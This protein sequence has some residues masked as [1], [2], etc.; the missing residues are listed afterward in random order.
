MD[1]ATGEHQIA[2]KTIAQGLREIVY[3]Y[4]H[5]I[6]HKGYVREQEWRMIK[7]AP[8]TKEIRFDTTAGNW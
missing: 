7:V 8:E 3:G 2:V 5:L 1:K 6:K 4:Y